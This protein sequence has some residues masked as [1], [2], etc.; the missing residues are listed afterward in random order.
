MPPLSH[1]PPR[2]AHKVLRQLVLEEEESRAPTGSLGDP[3]DVAALVVFLASKQ[4]RYVS[5]ATIQVDGASTT[6][7]F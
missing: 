4:A 7:L 2:L 3:A 1:H 6:A 5:G